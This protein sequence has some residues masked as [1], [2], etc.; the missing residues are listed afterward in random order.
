[1]EREIL[2]GKDFPQFLIDAVNAKQYSIAEQ[3]LTE[4]LNNPVHTY[5]SVEGQVNAL[6]YELLN[7]GRIEDAVEI[8]KLNT[9]I[10][11]LS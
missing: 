7:A 2:N 1:M 6:G 3:R 8:F 11:P 4:F 10:Y 9:K 5:V